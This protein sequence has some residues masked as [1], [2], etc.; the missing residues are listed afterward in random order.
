MGHR[1]PLIM[2]GT[3]AMARVPRRRLRRAPAC[4]EGDIQS[5]NLLETSRA[6]R[7]ARSPDVIASDGQYH[8]PFGIHRYTDNSLYCGCL[9]GDM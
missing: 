1:T 9:A 5:S 8:E 7:A 2:P 6:P 3:N 4:P